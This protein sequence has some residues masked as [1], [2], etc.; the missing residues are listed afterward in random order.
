MSIANWREMRRE[1]K[2]SLICS[3]VLI[4]VVGGLGMYEWLRK[5]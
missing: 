1:K 2:V 5:D 3:I 4:V